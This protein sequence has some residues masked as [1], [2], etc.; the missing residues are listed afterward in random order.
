MEKNII[1]WITIILMW[2]FFVIYPA[3]KG[4]YNN[5]ELIISLILLS[6][7]TFYGFIYKDE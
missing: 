3:I 6:V 4:N 5:L 2:L 7:L 1:S